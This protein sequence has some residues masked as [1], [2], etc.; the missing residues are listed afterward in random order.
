MEVAF[1]HVLAVVAFRRRQA[2]KTFLQNRIA[3]IRESWGKDEQLIAIANA[4]DAVFAPTICLAP[5]QVMRQVI[6]GVAIGA[7]VF[8]N[9]RPSTIGDIGSPAT[10]IA[11]IV[12]DFAEPVVFFG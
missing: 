4:G 12:G 3:L 2:E 5:R 11:F 10:P 7:V 1:L 9:R 6:P 8:A